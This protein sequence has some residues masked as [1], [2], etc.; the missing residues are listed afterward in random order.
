MPGKVSNRPAFPSGGPTLADEWKKTL[1]KIKR[2]IEENGYDE[3]RGVFIQAFDRAISAG[4][5]LYLFSEEFDTR[6]GEMLGNFPQALTY[7]SL[8]SAAVAL[9]E[10]IS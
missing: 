8:I 10:K 6:S 7:L 2:T 9:S 4:N 5:D 3:K 1:S